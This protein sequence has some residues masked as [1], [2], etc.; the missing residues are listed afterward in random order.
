MKKLLLFSLILLSLSSCR[1]TVG[2]GNIVSEKRTVR[3]FTGISVGEAFEVEV[4]TGPVT[5]V[6]VESDDNIIRY[7]ETNVSGD[8]LKIRLAD[9]NS[10]SDAHLKVYITVPGLLRIKASSASNV[11]VID[12]LTSKDKLFFNAS[13]SGEITAVV[14]APAVEARASSGGSIKLSGRTMNYTAGAS[15]GAE[16]KTGNLLS[17]NTTVSA[18]SGA[19]AKVHASV[20]L[21]ASASSGADIYYR[22]AASVQKNISSGGSVEK[23]D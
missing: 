9:G 18:S 17:E 4:K 16:I 10:I 6:T 2:S 14:D 8:D 23:Q 22:G 13:S 7:I 15:S 11:T 1:H 5:E 20:S 3:D 19:S 21:K 12:A